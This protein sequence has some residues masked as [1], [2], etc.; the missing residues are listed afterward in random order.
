MY[1]MGYQSHLYQKSHNISKNSRESRLYVFVFGYM[2]EYFYVGVFIKRTQMALAP[3][4]A[5]YRVST[6]RSKLS[7]ARAFQGDPW[8]EE[9]VR[10][11]LSF[12]CIF[13]DISHICTRNHITSQKTAGNPGCFLRSKYFKY[14]LLREWKAVD[15]YIYKST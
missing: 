11:E 10:N 7:K 3:D 4:G 9:I 2:C 14:D 12:G 15:I 6:R 5:N 1:I 8:K 13:W